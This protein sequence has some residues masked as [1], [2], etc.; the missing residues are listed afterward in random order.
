M[1]SLVLCF[2]S[3]TSDRINVKTFLSRTAP[4]CF[5]LCNW[6]LIR[7]IQTITARFLLLCVTVYTVRK[8]RKTKG[9]KEASWLTNPLAAAGFWKG[10][11]KE[12]NSSSYSTCMRT[13]RT[14]RSELWWITARVCC[15]NKD[16]L[17]R[18]SRGVLETGSLLWAANNSSHFCL[19]NKIARKKKKEEKKNPSPG[20][21]KD[22]R[23]E[24]LWTIKD[25]AIFRNYCSAQNNSAIYGIWLPPIC[26]KSPLRRVDSAKASD[27]QTVL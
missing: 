25:R 10:N 2:S 15:R 19:R 18:G 17:Y 24:T 3:S 22:D 13:E 20:A 6:L 26:P 4:L 5:L 23:G 27:V 16:D 7:L 9:G 8:K 21:S 1:L 14:P 12:M 11:E